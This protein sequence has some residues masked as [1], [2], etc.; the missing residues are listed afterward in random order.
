MHV[1]HIWEL[2]PFQSHVANRCYAVT[3][4]E[5]VPHDL[6]SAAAESFQET[7][8]VF[9]ADNVFA[10]VEANI[11]WNCTPCDIITFHW[12][13]EGRLQEHM[14]CLRV[15]RR[16]PIRAGESEEM[17]PWHALLVGYEA[18]R[19]ASPKPPSLDA[20]LGRLGL[21]KR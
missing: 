17:T 1:P 5:A 20:Y 6:M 13:E 11:E 8:Q 12:W 21:L 9:C 7:V 4:G 14:Y 16:D 3:Q 10:I 2:V 18:V 15:D 19:L